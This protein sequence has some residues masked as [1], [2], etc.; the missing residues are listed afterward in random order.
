MKATRL[1]SVGEAVAPDKKLLNK[2]LNISEATIELPALS[3]F[4]SANRCQY[5]RSTSFKYDYLL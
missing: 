1:T 5:F 2:Q 4:T 3:L